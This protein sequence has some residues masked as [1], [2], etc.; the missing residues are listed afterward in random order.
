MISLATALAAMASLSHS[1]NSKTTLFL[2]NSVPLPRNC[3]SNF[4]ATKTIVSQPSA[5]EP[6]RYSSRKENKCAC[7]A[8]WVCLS[9]LR[10]SFL[11]FLP[12]IAPHARSGYGSK[13]IRFMA[14]KKGKASFSASITSSFKQYLPGT[15]AFPHAPLGDSRGGNHSKHAHSYTAMLCPS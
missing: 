9:L 5:T 11:C 8:V 15:Q 2:V 3:L 4:G 6:A 13:S 12:V 14:M 10:V 7:L 1:L